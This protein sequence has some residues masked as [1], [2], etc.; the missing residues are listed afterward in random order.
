M[1][2]LGN[3]GKSEAE[4]SLVRDG[5]IQRF[6]LGDREM[7]QYTLVTGEA[8]RPWQIV[9][10][11]ESVWKVLWRSRG[12]EELF[13]GLGSVAVIGLQDIREMARVKGLR[14]YGG[15]P[16]M[17]GAPTEEWGAFARDLLILPEVE[18]EFGS[19]GTT[20]RVRLVSPHDTDDQAVQE[21]AAKRLQAWLATMPPLSEDL[22]A[23][24]Q[25]K[26]EPSL[27]EWI[28]LVKSTT[29]HIYEEAFAK[30]V[31]S[32]SCTLH[33]PE[34]VRPGA[35]LSRLAAI[36]EESYLFSLTTPEGLS[37]LGRSP[38]KLL[39]WED[40]HILVDA[41]AGTSG[42]GA[43]R[44]EDAR[45]AYNLALS[46]K[47]LQEHRIVTG[48]VAGI[49]R[50][51][52]ESFENTEKEKLLQLKNLQHIRSTFRGKC[53]VGEHP[54]GLLQRLHPTPAVGGHPWDIAR[55]F[56]DGNE[57]VSR[58]WYAGAVG[59]TDFTSGDF[60]IGIRSALL[61]DRFLKVFAG[62][63][64]VRDSDP[65]AEWLETALKMKN[66]LDMFPT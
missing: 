65:G 24:G 37:F 26:L 25:R 47:D 27:R 19:A 16:F 52:C 66:F 39:S 40:R 11:P 41:I 46:E 44:E 51:V 60:A 13:A 7:L 10:H 34:D 8:P 21:M 56:I 61:G 50:S 9:D 32:R 42:R 20:V 53:R 49:L 36:D 57:P 12:A 22:P 45:F 18:W 33:F 64:I 54:I 55:D 31:L 59:C 3:A 4:R 30:V 28:R 38:E 15:Q 2:N 35:L 14:W 5:L 43:S 6:L 63:G 58:G 1:R 29:G 62:S 17:D 23:A 48:Y